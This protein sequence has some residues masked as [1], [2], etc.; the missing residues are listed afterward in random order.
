MVLYGWGLVEEE[1][2]KKTLW[3]KFPVFSWLK[4]TFKFFSKKVWIREK[5][6]YFCTRF[7]NEAGI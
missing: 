2:F 1:N 3:I 7:E 5:G 4:K 6:L